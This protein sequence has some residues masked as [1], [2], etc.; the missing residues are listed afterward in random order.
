AGFESLVNA[1]YAYSRWWYGKE[2]G[3]NLSEMGTDLWINGV[4]GGANVAL[5]HYE[6]LQSN[7]ASV[8]SLW[9]KMYEA[10]NLCNAG[11]EFVN[12]SGLSP[13]L[14]LQR[15]AEIRFLRAFYYWHIVETWGRSEERRVGKRREGGE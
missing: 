14:Q 1:A 11:L 10:V 5:V 3:Y 13:D 7:Q 8:E 4:D 6:N 12:Q 2:D 9:A 15:E